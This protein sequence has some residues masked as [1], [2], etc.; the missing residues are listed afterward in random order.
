ML[1]N[2]DLVSDFVCPWCYIGKV[3]LYK[4]IASLHNE[5]P[6]LDFRIN[7]LP[8][9]LNPNTPVA[10]EPYRA[11]LEAKFGNAAAVD[12]LHARITE[13]G[14]P[15]GVHFAFDSM[16]VRPNTLAAHRLTYH[17]QAIGARQSRIQAITD[18][19]FDAHFVHG[20]NIGDNEVLADIA[21]ACG[22]NRDNTQA[23]LESGEDLG[24]VRR[25]AEQV[26]KQGIT[27]VP[28][29][30]IDRKLAVSGAQS[31]TAIGAAILQ[32]LS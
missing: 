10:G 31:S 14:A 18:A 24:N 19:I 15:D 26:K 27:G 5:H 17:L 8:Y 23:Y 13:A 7:W 1:L 22:E 3:R 11:F 9:F 29:F 6:D 32:A 25:M 4:A 30:I 16:H 2:I 21:L 12:A 20:K 28:F